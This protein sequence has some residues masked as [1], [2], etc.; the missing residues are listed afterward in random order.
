MCERE[1][2]GRDQVNLYLWRRCAE[3]QDEQYRMAPWIMTLE[4]QRKS[5]RLAALFKFD[6]RRGGQQ[7]AWATSRVLGT[8]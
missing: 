2:I 7:F 4:H 1:R 8:M 6:T 5:W 3:R